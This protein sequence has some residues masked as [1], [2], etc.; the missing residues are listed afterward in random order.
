MSRLSDDS[1]E[2][3]Q[4]KPLKK[5]GG[6]TIYQNHFGRYTS[7]VDNKKLR[8]PQRLGRHHNIKKSEKKRVEGGTRKEVNS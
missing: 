1:G 6:S 8:K 4:A 2:K 5:D 7:K 3:G